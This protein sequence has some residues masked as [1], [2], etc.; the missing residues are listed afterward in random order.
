MSQPVL[1][2]PHLLSISCLLSGLHPQSAAGTLLLVLSCLYPQL[3]LI[4]DRLCCCSED[5]AKDA[6]NQAKGK[7]SEAKGKAE[8]VKN[9]VKN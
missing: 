6:K 1:V 3:I 4:P 5:N 9:E 8:D 2:D 7:A